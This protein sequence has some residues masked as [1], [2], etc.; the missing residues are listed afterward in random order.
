MTT[1]DNNGTNTCRRAQAKG[2]MARLR[3][4]RQN[5]LGAAVL[6][7]L[8]LCAPSVLVA[9]AARAKPSR[10]TARRAKPGAKAPAMPHAAVGADGSFVPPTQIAPAGKTSKLPPDWQSLVSAGKLPAFY[11]PKDLRKAPVLS[12]PSA[13]LMDADTGQILWMKNPDEKHFPASTTKIM[14]G[15][16]FAERT[17]PTDVITCLDPKITQIEESS[18]HIKPWEKFTA[19]DLLYGFILRS[20][21]DGAV[22]I[23]EHVS[24]TVPKFADL[25]N[26]R[27][28]ELGATNTH[29]VTP[30]GL[31]DPNHYTT[32]RD[33][34]LIA[35]AALQN[36]KFA[37]AVRLPTRVI[38]R[39][40]LATDIKVSSKAK[41]SFYDKFPGADGVKTGWTHKA[42]HCFVGSATR[43]GR[44]LLSVVLASK[45]SAI[46]D[47]TPL[48]S[49][50]FKRF[51]A[52]FV[53][54]KGETTP[55]VS[56]KGGTVFNVATTAAKN[57]HAS[58]DT[59]GNLPAS[60]P[61]AAVIRAADTP[62]EGVS[63]TPEPPVVAPA[64]EPTAPIAK[65]PTDVSIANV[66][67]TVET[68]VESDDVSA[69][70]TKGQVVGKLVA[71]IG[72]ADVAE[73]PLVADAD[74]PRSA[75]VAAAQSMTPSSGGSHVPL[76]GSLFGGAGALFVG[77]MGYRYYATATEKARTQR[78][79]R[80]DAI[81]SANGVPRSGPNGR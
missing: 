55:P 16:L 65:T 29:F 20:A 14:T 41:K 62:A 2:M 47:T 72:N 79:R 9:P 6:L 8:F 31:H 21:N 60:V 13:V 78:K 37:E 46:S 45:N 22:V 42:N 43:D 12:A 7:T 19:K 18:L 68:R 39:S 76:W 27:A 54:R 56:V 70:I 74:V 5:G 4:N 51:G 66:P 81:R 36:E 23:A 35:R 33:M 26:A 59:L 44:R 30:N 61:P 63:A 52:T 25:M 64:P 38:S 10:K 17:Q 77:L 73:T 24:G 49:W 53:A 80:I 57:L 75:L 32:A 71:R 58:Y 3:G 1:A 34:A 50:G 48:L 40:K 69:P 67:P 28:K 15:L 11:N